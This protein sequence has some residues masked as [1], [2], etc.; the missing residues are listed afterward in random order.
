M[1]IA[2]ICCEIRYQTIFY[3]MYLLVHIYYVQRSKALELPPRRTL[4]PGWLIWFYFCCGHR[5]T[6]LLTGPLQQTL[7]NPWYLCTMHGT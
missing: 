7:Q 5:M 3:Y 4:R 1:G 6:I 2:T